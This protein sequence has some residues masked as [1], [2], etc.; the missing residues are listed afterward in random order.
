MKNMWVADRFRFAIALLL[1]GTGLAF[2]LALLDRVPGI[3]GDEAVGAV[4]MRDFSAGLMDWPW[5][6]PTNRPLSP[7]VMAMM[8]V[9]AEWLPPDFGYMRLV[10]AFSHLALLVAAWFTLKARLDTRQRLL[11]LLLLCALPLHTAFARISWDPCLIPLMSYL[12]VFFAI[13]RRFVA[14]NAMLVLAVLTHSTCIFLAPLVYILWAHELWARKA[15]GLALARFVA[16][17]AAMG[18]FSLYVFSLAGGETKSQVTD[19]IVSR[20]AHPG[21]LLD[22]FGLMF[23]TLIG[24]TSFS[25]FVGT[26]MES[27]LLPPLKVIGV[28]A[29]LGLGGL[30]RAFVVKGKGGDAVLLGAWLVALLMFYLLAGNEPLA[31]GYQRYVLWVGVPFVFIAYRALGLLRARDGAIL[32]V[33]ALFLVATAYGYFYKSLTRSIPVYPA[34]YASGSPEPKRAAF[35]WIR[36]ARGA[37]PQQG[38]QRTR[39]LAENWWLY[40]PGRYWLYDDPIDFFHAEQPIST[41]LPP[42]Q[43]MLSVAQIESVLKGRGF[44]I[45]FVNG[46]FART[47]ERVPMAAGCAAKTFNDAGGAPLI[48]I[49]HCAG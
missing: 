29:L 35:E 43:Q 20:V 48:R 41:G 27:K 26:P 14:A 6:T 47:M 23:Y 10:P 25:E 37:L 18:L 40:W 28:L 12:V 39:I 16:V 42:A 7:I 49:W 21:G 1:L 3:N 4:W 30:W 2:K 33:S 5:W 34:V 9:V 36:E 11:F 24:N 22:F 17:G 45:G 8:Y 46:P 31:V 32:V 19:G 13:D 44:V 38:G 15:G